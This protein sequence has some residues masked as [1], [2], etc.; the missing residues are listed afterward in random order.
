VEDYE[1][2]VTS[3]VSRTKLWVLTKRNDNREVEKV[4]KGCCEQAFFFLPSST[5]LTSSTLWFSYASCNYPHFHRRHDTR[6]R[7]LRNASPVGTRYAMS[8]PSGFWS[9]GGGCLPSRF[10][11]AS[12]AAPSFRPIDLLLLASLLHSSFFLP[13]SSASAVPLC[14]WVRTIKK[15]HAASGLSMASTSRF[16][17]SWASCNTV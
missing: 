3:I 6:Y 13:L 14:L 11:R 16:A 17:L 10:L 5:S 15:V 8:L 7:R 9:L 1:R 12:T 2:R 4:E